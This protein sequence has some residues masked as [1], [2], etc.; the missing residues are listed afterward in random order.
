MVSNPK[1]ALLELSLELNEWLFSQGE[2]YVMG[3][4]NGHSD[5]LNCGEMY[6]PKADEWTQVPELRTNRCNAG[7][8]H[9]LPDNTVNICNGFE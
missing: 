5:E 6:N 2:L 4:S 9:F 1:V 8:H 3:G 7:M